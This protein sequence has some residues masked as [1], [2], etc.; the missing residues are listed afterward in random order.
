M[1]DYS[2][3][4]KR[5]V[6]FFPTWSDIRKRYS[7]SAGGKLLGAVTEEVIELEQA[8]KE[9]KR[10]YFLDTYEGHEDE[11][12]AFS[13]RAPVGMLESSEMLNVSYN[14]EE[15][16]VTDDINR[17][18]KY[19]N[20]AYYEEGYIYINDKMYNNKTIQ[21][22]VNGFL[23]EEELQKT[24]V[25]NIFDEFA[26]FVGLER[27]NDEKN[28]DLVKR[29]LRINR[30]KPNGSIEGLQ[31]AIMA[32]LLTEFPD[33]SRDEIQFEQINDENLRKGY[34]KFTAGY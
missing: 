13:Y 10:Y 12:V 28:S 29:I 7:T 34:D 3:M 20:V 14:N 2:K 33:I 19:E 24:H 5:A 1:F 6:E 17:L 27:H 18:L 9:Y 26:C 11:V 32:E 30:Y 21:L 16:E 23:I 4:I 8:I 31:N 22:Y 15:I 25:W